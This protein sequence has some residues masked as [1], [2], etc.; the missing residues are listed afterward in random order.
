MFKTKTNLTYLKKIKKATENGDEDLAD[1][2]INIMFDSKTGKIRNDKVLTVT[3]DLIEKGYDVL[4]K[5]INKKISYDGIEYT[6]TNKQHKQFK[7]IYSQA[8]DAVKTMVNSANFDKLDDEAK[9]K[10]MTFVYD[11]YYDLVLEDMLGVDLEEKNLLFAHAIPIEQLAMA[12]AQARLYESDQDKNGK[13]INGS[14]KAKV[15]AFVQSLRLSA[16]QK[17]MIMGYLGYTNKLGANLVK[18]YIQRL[19]LTKEQKKQLYAWSGYSEE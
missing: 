18:N 16:T 5:N 17:Y 6:L 13:T 8:T 2:L 19:K 15:Q 3:R 9:A 7:K 14:K 12:V 1:A 11:Y 4:P 10:A